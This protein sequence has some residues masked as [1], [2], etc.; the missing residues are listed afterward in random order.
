ML[1]GNEVRTPAPGCP[2]CLEKRYH[3]Q[4][5]F[6]KFHPLAGHGYSGGTWTHPEA[7]RASDL[8]RLAKVSGSIEAPGAQHG[9]SPTERRD[10]RGE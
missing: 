9:G 3:S 10:L 7:K 4:G 8:E 5:E 1:H 2:A 6:Q